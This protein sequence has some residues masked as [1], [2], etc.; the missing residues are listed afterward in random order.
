LLIGAARRTDGIL[1]MP[2]PRVFQTTLDDFYVKYRLVCQ[3]SP[4]DPLERAQVVSAL[5]ASIQDL[6]N[7][8]GVQIMSPHYLGDP[9]DPKVV[10]RARWYAAPAKR[11]GEESAN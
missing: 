11:E 7:E 9:G 10:P 8:H 4:T 1:D 5:N 3:A 2:P 6:F